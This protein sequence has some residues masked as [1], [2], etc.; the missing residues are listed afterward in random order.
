LE[1]DE[2]KMSVEDILRVTQGFMESRILLSAAELDVFTILSRGPLNAD[3]AA[4]KAGADVR[5]L[6]FLLDALVGMGFLVKEDPTYRCEDRV[7]GLLS[8]DAPGSILPMLLHVNSLWERWSRLTDVVRHG[9]A[10]ELRYEFERNKEELRAFIGAMHVVASRLANSIVTMVQPGPARSLIDIGGGSGSYTIAFL[11]AVPGMRATLFDLPPVVE[12]A[13]ERLDR[14][15][16]L[17]RVRLVGGDFHEQELPPGHD[18]ALISAVIHSNSAEQNL[19]LYSKTFRSLGS[20]GRILIRDHVMDPDRAHPKDGAIFAI[21]MLVGTE[22]GG[23]YTYEE[24]KADLTRAG[25]IRVRLLQG[26]EHMDGVV[27]AF[28]P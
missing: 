9:A 22:G 20:G 23:T 6:T 19:D 3:E 14:E 17:D 13:R 25:F 2:G 5:A 7:S 12:L 15:G 24:I 26:G 11:Q 28:K 16:L 18:L 21:N 4:R 27:E 8:K 1:A 10:P